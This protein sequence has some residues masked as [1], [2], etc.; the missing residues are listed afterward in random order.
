MYVR[1][2]GKEMEK[3]WVPRLSSAAEQVSTRAKKKRL[4]WEV[5]GKANGGFCGR[6]GRLGAWSGFLFFLF[7]LFLFLTLALLHEGEGMELCEE[8]GN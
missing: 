8:W 5:E 6:F 4:T 2:L 1:A 3:D 7:F